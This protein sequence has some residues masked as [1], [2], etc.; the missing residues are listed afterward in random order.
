MHRAGRE[1]ERRPAATPASTTV[2]I[3]AARTT[4]PPGRTSTTSSTRTPAP[5]SARQRRGTAPSAPRVSPRTMATCWPETAVRCVIET[6][7]MSS[8]TCPGRA[9]SSPSATPGTRA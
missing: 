2:P 9:E 5:M 6:V 4:E 8:R 1:T 7:R 3:A